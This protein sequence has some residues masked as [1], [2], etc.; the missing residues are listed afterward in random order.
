MSCH[1]AKQLDLLSYG[2]TCVHR[3]DSRSKLAAGAFF[4]ICVLSFPKYSV[5]PLVPLFILP[6]LL[7]VLGQVPLRLIIRMLLIACP[8]ALMVGVFNPLLDSA[9]WLK[10][11]TLTLSAG[12][13]SFASI[14]LR[15]IL[16]LSMVLVIVGTTSFPQL[17]HGLCQLG[18][19][20]PFVVQLQFLYRYLFLLVEEGASISQARQVRDPVHK[21]P[22]IHTGKSMLYCLLARSWERAHRVFLCLK[23]RGFSGS[24][25]AGA[26][27]ILRWTDVLF[28]I[29][30]VCACL[31]L[32]IFPLAQSLGQWLLRTN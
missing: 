16:S 18:L 28:L 6:L 9:V 32:R 19:P 12:W 27:Q 3:L 14:V 7:A 24:F 17:L 26:S 22:N 21:Y 4:I 23:T 29:L 1:L 31:V 25:I 11:G 10:I 15:F 5:S 2:K 30:W 13:L 8:F 20:Q